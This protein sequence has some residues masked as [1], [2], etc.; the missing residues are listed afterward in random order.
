[1]AK[2]TKWNFDSERGKVRLSQVVSLTEDA[3]QKD[4]SVQKKAKEALKLYGRIKKFVL[5]RIS[6]DDGDGEENSDSLSG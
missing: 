3:E 6:P 1:M 4:W 5:D 2:P